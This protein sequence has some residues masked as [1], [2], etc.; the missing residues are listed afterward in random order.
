MVPLSLEGTEFINNAHFMAVHFGHCLSL[1]RKNGKRGNLNF[2]CQTVLCYITTVPPKSRRITA[3]QFGKKLCENEVEVQLYFKV[4][5]REIK[6][7]R[8]GLA[9]DQ[10]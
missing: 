2:K 4:W 7:G 1:G 8:G 9:R 3:A 5:D 10:Y 6:R